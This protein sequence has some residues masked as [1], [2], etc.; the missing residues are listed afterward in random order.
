MEPDLP[1]DILHLIAGKLSSL[2]CYAAFRSVC[3]LWRSISLKYYSHLVPPRPPWLMFPYRSTVDLNSRLCYLCSFDGSKFKRF[4]KVEIPEG[5]TYGCSSGTWLIFNDIKKDKLRVWNPLSLTQILLPYSVD[6]ENKLAI[7]RP[8]KVIVSC[9]GPLIKNPDNV[10]FGILY[11]L[12]KL[13]FIRLGDKDWT[14]IEVDFLHHQMPKASAMVP[15]FADIIFHH[16]KLYAV[17]LSGMVFVC[18]EGVHAPRYNDHH[19][20]HIKAKMLIDQSYK[21]HEL[22]VAAQNSVHYLVEVDGDL[23]HVIQVLLSSSSYKSR[24]SIF[25]L[26]SAT[27]KSYP[28]TSKSDLKGHSLFLSKWGSC[29]SAIVSETSR[30]YVSLLH[31]YYKLTM[32]FELAVFDYCKE[33]Q[34]YS[35][36]LRGIYRYHHPPPTWIVPTLGN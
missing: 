32:G 16:G 1:D 8:R 36:L 19:L 13:A 7:V 6:S 14:F 33:G 27:K 2:V 11:N 9:T 23:L 4:F 22:G 31:A 34:D 35:T 29:N 20:Q 5:C 26:D 18:E 3:R 12:S 28:V 30:I 10:I 25:K 15:E 17:N 24:L 21:M